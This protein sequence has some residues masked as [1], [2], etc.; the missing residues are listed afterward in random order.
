MISAND[1]SILTVVPDIPGARSLLIYPN[2]IFVVSTEGKIFRYD[3]ETMEL[4]EENQIASASAAGFS[5]IVFCSRNNSAYLIGAFGKILEVSLPDCIVTDEFSVCQSPVK[6]A[7]APGSRNLFVG[8]GTTSKVFQVLTSNNTVYGSTDLFFNMFFMEALPVQP[9]QN[10][11][12]VLVSTTD[13]LSMVEVLGVGDLRSILLT[14]YTSGAFLDFVSVPN[15]SFFV[16]IHHDIDHDNFSV[17]SYR[18]TIPFV[19]PPEPPAYNYFGREGIAG[20]THLLTMGRDYQHAYILSYLGDNVSRLSAY[21][22]ISQEITKE[23]D[24]PG[25]PVDLQASG[26]GNIYVLTAQQ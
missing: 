3:S 6:L 12:S 25:Y 23:L 17:G 9:L 16:A 8:D 26:S 1:F 22:Y 4:I 15:D 21:S 24:F 19:L 20:N 10:S 18:L 2:I 14:K 11:D 5:E 13:A 7:L